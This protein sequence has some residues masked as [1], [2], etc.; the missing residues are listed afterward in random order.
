MLNVQFLTSLK[1]QHCSFIIQHSQLPL[2]WYPTTQIFSGAMAQELAQSV[3]F[4]WLVLFNQTNETN[5]INQ[6][7]KTGWRTFSAAC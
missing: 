6:M 3:W 2:R 7:N 1:I 4:I 5:Q